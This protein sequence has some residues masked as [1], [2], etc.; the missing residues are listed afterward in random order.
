ML[1]EQQIPLVAIH[2][3]DDSYVHKIESDILVDVWPNATLIE[4][5]GL[6]H[7]RIINSEAAMQA[8]CDALLK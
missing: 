5:Q 7:R 4:T 3:A 6:G 2:D 1:A 8:F